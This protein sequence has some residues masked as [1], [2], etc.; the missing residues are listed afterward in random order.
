MKTTRR[1]LQSK[2]RLSI[3]RDQA[4][5]L[6]FWARRFAFMRDQEAK[7]IIVGIPYWNVAEHPP[8]LERH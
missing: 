3:L 1:F 8:G 6:A 5:Y 2:E 4:F 7:G